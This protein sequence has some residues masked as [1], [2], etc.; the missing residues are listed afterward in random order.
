MLGRGFSS[1][2]SFFVLLVSQFGGRG[3]VFAGELGNEI[4]GGAEG[5]EIH[6]ERKNTRGATYGSA[7]AVFV[8]EGFGGLGRDGLRRSNAAA[9]DGKARGTRWWWSDGVS[10]Y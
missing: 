4:D 8:D 2:C 1:R 9:A 7:G 6:R 5:G 10:H 3:L